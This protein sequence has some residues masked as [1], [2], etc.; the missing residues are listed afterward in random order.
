[1]QENLQCGA[2]QAKRPLLLYIAL[3]GH[4]TDPQHAA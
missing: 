4:T 2:Q 3:S 1:M